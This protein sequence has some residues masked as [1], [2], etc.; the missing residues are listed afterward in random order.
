MSR[1]HSRSL[2]LALLVAAPFAL[3]GPFGCADN[4]STI[5]I[6]HVLAK[7]EDCAFTADPGGAFIGQGT[8]DLQFTSSYAPFVLVGN[9]LVPQGDDEALKTETS[10]VQLHGAEVHLTTA[11]GEGVQSFSTTCAGTIDAAAGPEPGYGVTQVTMIPPGAVDTPGSY[12]ARVTVFG[13]T[14]GNQDV[15]SGEFTFPIEVCD[16]CLIFFNKESQDAGTCVAPSGDP[17]GLCLPGQDGLTDCS[18]LP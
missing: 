1:L 8:M 7:T 18:L 6:R 10:R 17:I 3:L 9:Q 12:L 13:E 14:L 4:K 2:G 5:F 15:E 16:G 11:G